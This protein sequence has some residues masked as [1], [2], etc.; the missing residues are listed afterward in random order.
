MRTPT[1]AMSEELTAIF[2][3]YPPVMKVKEVASALRI[4]IK[5]VYAYAGAGDLPSF[6]LRSNLLFLKTEV[7][8]WVQ[9]QNPR[10]RPDTG[11]KRRN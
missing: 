6:R 8:Q 7:V 9:R 11:D 4:N 2:R 3:D 10:F 1:D 5:T